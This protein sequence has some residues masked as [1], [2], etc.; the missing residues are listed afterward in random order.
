LY[1]RFKE[2]PGA[3]IDCVC[4]TL[5]ADVHLRETLDAWYKVAP[6][7]RLL[8][9]DGGSKDDTMKILGSYPRVNV[10]VYPGMTTGK[11]WELLKDKVQTPFFIWVDVGKIPR[12]GWYDEMMH[13]MELD[14]GDILGSLRFNYKDGRLEE[15]PIIRNPQERLLGGPWLVWKEGVRSYHVDDD[16]VQRCLDIVIRKQLEDAGG[17]YHLVTTTSHVCYLPVPVIDKEEL[18]KRH[19]MNAQGIVKYIT[20]S[21]AKEHASYLLDDHWMLMMNNLPRKW[22]ADTN[23]LW[24]PILKRWRAKR[25]LI[26]KLERFIYHKV[27]RK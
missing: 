21:Y 5:N 7:R 17:N 25:L 10:W 1:D 23:E 14:K 13:Q 24:I 4:L 3:G 27:L 2:E 8:V 19:I 15:D 9:I 11:A 18:R 22:I 20:P 12:D 6:V 26:A 16:F